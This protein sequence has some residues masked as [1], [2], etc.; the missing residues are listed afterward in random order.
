MPEGYKVDVS[1][2]VGHKSP[3]QKVCIYLLCFEFG[4]RRVGDGHKL[5]H[6]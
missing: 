6:G 5:T 3:T 1:K 4:T 2:A